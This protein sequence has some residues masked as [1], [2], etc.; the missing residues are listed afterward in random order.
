M[1]LLILREIVAD[2]ASCAESEVSHLDGINLKSPGG[3]GLSP[4]H[5]ILQ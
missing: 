2:G 3:I 1:V 5:A 4:L